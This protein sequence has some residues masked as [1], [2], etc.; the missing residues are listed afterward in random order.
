MTIHRAQVLIDDRDLPELK[1]IVEKLSEHPNNVATKILRS[2]ALQVQAVAK[3]PQP[4]A[5][6]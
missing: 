5:T 2:V 4:A 6:V 3:N 1:R